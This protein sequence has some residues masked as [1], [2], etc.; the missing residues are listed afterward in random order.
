MRINEFD[1][2]SDKRY[3]DI[4]VI[5]YFYNDHMKSLNKKSRNNQTFDIE[6]MTRS[7][8]LTAVLFAYVKCV[9]MYSYLCSQDLN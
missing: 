9:S 3:K 1:I 5:T 2:E 6:F 4:Y 8:V 7:F